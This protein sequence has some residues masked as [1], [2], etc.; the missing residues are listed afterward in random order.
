[1]ETEAIVEIAR[2]T[3]ITLVILAIV[4][5][6]T[7]AATRP[8][9][10]AP[11]E[12]PPGPDKLLA[13]AHSDIQDELN[14]MHSRDLSGWTNEIPQEIMDAHIR[15]R[16]V[17]YEAMAEL[18]RRRAELASAVAEDQPPPKWPVDDLIIS[19]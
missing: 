7:Y 2:F 8:Y 12:S 13:K 18:A 17:L 19:S 9:P 4:A 5:G 3:G 1:M 16:K 11:P 6:F 14:R 10:P 15:D